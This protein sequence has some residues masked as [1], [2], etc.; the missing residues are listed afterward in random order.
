VF[1]SEKFPNLPHKL[2]ASS[3]V[4]DNVHVIGEAGFIGL[5][6][7]DVLLAEDQPMLAIA[8]LSISNLQED[9]V[10]LDA[11]ARSC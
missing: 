2:G 9:D 6:L 5:Y 10:L 4:I 11:I 7:V 1:F 3:Q 8:D